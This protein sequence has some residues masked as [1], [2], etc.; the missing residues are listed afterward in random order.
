MVTSWALGIWAG[1]GWLTE[2]SGDRAA[3]ASVGF[4]LGL[5]LA[6][7]LRDHVPVAFA[8]SGLMLNDRM[9]FTERVVLCTS[10]VCGDP[11]DA[12]SH[13]EASLLSLEMG[14]QHRF[15]SSYWTSL[16]PAFLMGYAW[17]PGGMSRGISCDG[18]KSVEIDAIHV[19]GL[20]LAPSFKLSSLVGKATFAFALRSEF[21]LTGDL[22]NRTLLGFEIGTE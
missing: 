4:T 10:G 22:S 14:Y 15:W 3:T 18:C 13:A 16:L 17:N 7:T 5:S 8:F 11:Y 6:M 20:Y 19:G 12:E 21:F 1:A 2:G 9:P